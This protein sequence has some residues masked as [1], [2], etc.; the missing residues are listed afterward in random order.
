MSGLH[1]DIA[2]TH[3]S[4]IPWHIM[5]VPMSRTEV[6]VARTA[7]TAHRQPTP[8]AALNQH[9]RNLVSQTSHA[10]VASLYTTALIVEQLHVWSMVRAGALTIGG[11]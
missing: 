10:A 6:S 4:L 3:A 2:L 11:S 5:T 8:K 9:L 7:R 1:V